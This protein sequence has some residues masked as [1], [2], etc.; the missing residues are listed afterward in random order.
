MPGA[1]AL[2]WQILILKVDTARFPQKNALTF[3]CGSWRS[4]SQ[5]SG[6]EYEW[7]PASRERSLRPAQTKAGYAG[8]HWCGW[9]A[10]RPRVETWESRPG[11]VDFSRIAPRGCGQGGSAQPGRTL[12][13]L[14][15]PFL[16]RNPR[17]MPYY[18]SNGG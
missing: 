11:G 2:E 17:L 6:L 10:G 15:N 1:P 14:A 13:C 4:G 9:P 3:P 8:R 12:P 7:R 18:G 16:A 5:H